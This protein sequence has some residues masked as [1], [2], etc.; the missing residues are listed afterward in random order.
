MTKKLLLFAQRFPPSIGGSPSAVRFLFD[1]FPKDRLA[2]VS[3][4]EP[5]YEQPI[6][7][8]CPQLR[9][10]PNTSKLYRKI[11]KSLIT[12]APWFSRKA[13]DL[14]PISDIGALFVNFPGGAFLLA[15]W[16]FARRHRLPLIVYVHDIFKGHKRAPLERFAGRLLEHRVF[17]DAHK[18]YCVSEALTDFYAARYPDIT[19]EHLPHCLN[20]EYSEEALSHRK[21]C[22]EWKQPD[23]KLI[24][25]TGQIY[26]M[27]ADPILN[28]I[29]AVKL[30]GDTRLKVVVSS[31]D[32]PHRLERFGLVEEPGVSIVNLPSREELIDLQAQADILFNSVSFQDVDSIQA[33]TLFPLKTTEYLQLGKPMIVHG[34]P[35]TAFVQYARKQGFAEVVD[36]RDPHLLA[37]AIEKLI[38]NPEPASLQEGRERELAIR[39]P[40]KAVARIMKDAGLV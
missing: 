36:R 25:Y 5:G 35:E 1:S 29:D 7:F 31:P 2:V 28:L 23:E 3:L 21:I 34:P 17:R 10:P 4:G 16:R 11:D 30:V 38:N 18:I 6:D 15:G 40:A 37:G 9:F 33:R 14:L 24:V 32:P 22:N 8:G 20:P 39:N 27:T 26:A 19:F 13:G 12:R